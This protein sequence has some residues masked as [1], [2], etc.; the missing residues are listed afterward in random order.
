ML[1][2]GA[3]IS[4]LTRVHRPRHKFVSIILF[5][6]LKGGEEDD[7]VSSPSENLVSFGVL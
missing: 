7:T 2:N 5:M 4:Q 3:D 6:L 1:M